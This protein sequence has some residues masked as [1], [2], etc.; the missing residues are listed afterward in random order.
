MTPI[1]LLHA[2]PLSARM[3]D[4]VVPALRG[5]GE[6]LAPDLP[7]FGGRPAPASEPSV[8]AYADDVARHLDEAGADRAVLC[9]LSMGG[10]VAMAF[11]RRHPERLAGLVLA[12]TKASADPE[13]ARDNRERIATTLLAE[14]TPRVLLE[15]VAPGLVGE[16]TKLRRPDVVARVRRLVSEAAPEGVA[17]AQRAMARRPASF[18]TLAALQVPALVVVGEQDA[19]TPVADARA[20][21]DAVPDGRLVVLPDAGHLPAMESPAEFADAVLAYTPS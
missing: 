18:E 2:F 16:T 5:A 11:A 10:Y 9:G 13:R 6:V 1:V 15:D 7:G 19:L 8:G 12:D 3:W 21:V 17:W 4:D 20:M 14:R